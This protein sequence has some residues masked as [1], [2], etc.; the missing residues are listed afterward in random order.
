MRD[1]GYVIAGGTLT[2]GSLLVWFVPSWFYLPAVDRWIL[3]GGLAILVLL[4]VFAIIWYMRR[5]S[6]ARSQAA[7]PE[8]PA[9]AGGDEIDVLLREAEARLQAAGLGRQA[10]IANVPVIVLVGEPGSTKT[11]CMIHSGL[12]P[13]LLAGQ[14]YQEAAVVPTRT[15]NVWYAGK[16][17]F[18]EAGGKLL[19]EPP[20]WTRLLRRLAPGRLATVAGKSEQAPRAAVVLFD[21][22]NF[23]RPGAAEA[24]AA[25]ARNLQERLGEISQTLGIS[26]PVYVLF[27][28]MDRV[29]FFAEFIRNLSHEETRQVFGVTLPMAA[30]GGQGVY[31]EQQTVRLTAAFNQL[32]HSLADRRL[33]FLPRENDLEMVPG[34]YEFP[35]EFAKLRKPLVQ[36]LVDL[37][38]PSQLRAN[39]F[40]RGFYFCGVRAVVVQEMAP[41]PRSAGRAA[42]RPVS[43]SRSGATGMFRAG[44][45]HPV[46]GA[47]SPAAMTPAGTKRVPQWVFLTH[48][49][50]SVILQDRAALG[51]SGA[52]VK[53]NFWR[54][55]LWAAAA[56]FCFIAA[57]GF[58]VSYFGNRALENRVVE[59]A[60]GIAAAE[61]AT[62]GLPAVEA[63]RRLETLRQSVETLA[64]YQREGPP[65]RLR[66]FL[67]VGGELYPAA[68]RA[69]F[70]RFHQLLFGSTQ[71]GLLSHL[72]RLPAAPDPSAPY[73]FTYDTLKA[74]L[75][76]TTHHEKSTRAFLSPLLSD[77]WLAG[78]DAG[79]ERPQLAQKQFDFYSEELK[80][81][82]PF[83]S[84]GE[85]GSVDRARRYLAQFGAKERVYRLMLAEVSSKNPP[86][87][88]NRQ[89]PGFSQVVVNNRE[90]EGAFTRAGWAAMQEAMKN[91]AKY[92]GG[93]E[94]VLGKQ[95]ITGVDLARLE[96]ELREI[97]RNDYLKQWR[98]FLRATSITRYADL[99]DAAQ[100]LGTLSSNQAPLLALFWL[101]SHHTAAAPELAS[102]FQPPQFVVPPATQGIFIQPSNQAYMQ[103]LLNLQAAVEAV[104]GAGTG[105]QVAAGQTVAKAN[106]ARSVTRQLSFSFRPDPEGQVDGRVKT[107]LE[108]PITQVEALLK[109]MGPAELR[110]KGQGLCN[111]FRD[112]MSRYPFNPKA[113]VQATIDDFNGVFRPGDGA[114][115][116]FYSESLQNLIVK[117]G[118][119]Y[120]AKSG[121]PMTVSLAF[122]G[123]FNRAAAFS[124]AVYKGAQQPKL[125][126]TLRSNLV[127]QNQVIS[128]AIDGQTLNNASGKT[129]S[130][131]FT[132]PGT[133]PAGARLTVKFGGEP[134]Q[135]PRYDG[136]W[137]VFDFFADSEEKA[138]LSASVYGLEW[139]L[140][141]GQ[142]GRQV[143]TA[144]GQPVSVRFDLDM[145]GA[146]PV[147][148]KGYFA[149]WNC[150]ADVAR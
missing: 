125:A 89:F 18:V 23:L 69:Y 142:A 127:G 5:R 141:T 65:L 82:N 38:R 71:T 111:Q 115:G 36:F 76:T 27:T 85:A 26:L 103:A 43:D 22:E 91:A 81:A 17:V 12:E 46:P 117:E 51:A 41:A 144:A 93:E 16:S 8:A 9:Q 92:S 75:I 135:W 63:L 1:I 19:A 70:G 133:P 77:R 84:V 55:L 147:F 44:A 106:E 113:T 119:Q 6:S 97:Y 7:S 52:S 123:F 68:R 101:V 45:L 2:V 114:L 66:W 24:A 129:A 134:F 56:A 131:Q 137:G 31:A 79:Q 118:Q 148:R 109:G 80:F 34:A 104:A 149:G 59:A 100:K 50:H 73:G 54:R 110:A 74:Y 14:V 132:W 37:G 11:C 139:S 49:F 107:L 140:R 25:S 32:F 39:P 64:R 53:A 112:L 78:R 108:D 105:D 33:D 122:L 42:E 98:E 58:T 128:L 146:P 10:R 40:L 130:Q 124:D 126:Y 121:G 88:Y 87:N 57:I 13:E 35:R 143:T 29:A 67:Y 4:A 30:A 3:R 21:A 20:Q 83:S 95:A 99:K 62:A 116:K 90:V 48:L 120:V 136:L 61:S 145:M 60:R 138:Q 150:V 28:R 47:G 94:W 86:V 96:Q 102:A 15:V 72:Q